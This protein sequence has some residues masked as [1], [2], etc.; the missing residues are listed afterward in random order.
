MDQH[1]GSHRGTY[2]QGGKHGDRQPNLYNPYGAER[3]DFSDIPAHRARR[4]GRGSFSNQT[5][6]RGR[7]FSTGSYGRNNYASPPVPSTA[8]TPEMPP[9]P[10]GGPG[11]NDVEPFPAF[12]DYRQPVEPQQY[13][14]PAPLHDI[15]DPIR[16]CGQTWIGPENQTV[17]QL[18]VQRLPQMSLHIAKASLQK[19]VQSLIGPRDVTVDVRDGKVIKE[20]RT[21]PYAFLK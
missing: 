7:K 21:T 11:P 6:G 5:T 4:N 19:H 17:R 8:Y 18:W 15:S 12:H 9:Y 10:Y 3:P 2:Y 20:G 16:G 14:A 1:R 13:D